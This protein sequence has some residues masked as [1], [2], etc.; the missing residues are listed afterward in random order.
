MEHMAGRAAVN[1]T[2]LY[3]EQAGSGQPL[4]LIHGFTLNT[5]M[6]ED[7]FAIFARHY[8]VIHYDMRGFG[9]SARPTK[10]P[11]TAVDD[12]C[13]LLDALGVNRTVVLGL[14]RGGGVAIDFALAYPEHTSALV[15]VDPALGGWTWSEDFS[16]SMD[17]LAI[18][19]QTQGVEA[20]RQRWLAHPFFLPA[21]ERPELAARLAQIVASYSSW[22]WLYTSPER[23]VDL[24][25]PRPLEQISVPTLLVMGER[26]IGE[27]QV[28]AR[29][30]ASSIP[31]LTKHVLPGVGHMANME[32]P[33]AFNEAVLGFLGNLKHFSWST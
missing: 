31:Q 28:I 23:D 14:S 30:I 15:L 22:S 8:R 10:E 24:P 13:A 12:L 27:F 17:E 1:G 6:W 26:D 7:Q 16:R 5:Q 11:F 25:T 9:R 33:E 21:R 4:V 29:H 19:A 32:V 2:H 3:Y 18:T 20:A